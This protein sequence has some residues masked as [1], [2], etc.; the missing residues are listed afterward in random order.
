MT[1][2]A[3]SAATAATGQT[4]APLA[5]RHFPAGPTGFF[6]APVLVSG[7][8]EAVLIDGGFTLSDGRALAEAITA[9]GKTLTTIFVSQSDPDY[10]FGLGPV[11]AAFPQARI[12]AAPAT[13]AAINANVQ[14]KLDTW[15]PQ[16]GDNGPRTLADVVVPAASDLRALT[17]DGQSIDIVDAAGMTDR[18]Y[19]WTPSLGAIFGG[20]LVF[21]GV[22][23]WTADT[24]SPALRAAWVANLDAMAARQPRVVVPGHMMPGAATDATAI[25]YTRAYLVAF[26]EELPKA[27]NSAAL[28]AAMQ[29]RFPNA[30]MG[31]ALDI[32]AKVAKGEMPWG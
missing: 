6:R 3:A 31:V 15:G 19:L 1:A 14:K 13:V 17:V 11:R 20:V 21:S 32:G 30:G 7:A 24:N 29:A 23:V 2:V 4:A 9:T 25:A 26:D 5:W 22:H 18:R 27:A 8:R 28:I 16:L 10:Y 12:I